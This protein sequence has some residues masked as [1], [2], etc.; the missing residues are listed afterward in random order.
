MFDLNFKQVF[1]SLQKA[2]L[3]KKEYFYLPKT[4]NAL[5]I[6]QILE[7]YG[8]IRF[9]IVR[10]NSIKVYIKW[11]NKK[12][13]IK[14]KFLDCQTATKQTLLFLASKKPNSVF[15]LST[16]LGLLCHRQAFELNTFGFLFIE[17][18]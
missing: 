18:F 12:F 10:Q 4:K 3:E 5:K 2:Q 17:I 16:P 11:V 14:F 15:I 9:F 8:F 13:I 7:K 1:W 6:L